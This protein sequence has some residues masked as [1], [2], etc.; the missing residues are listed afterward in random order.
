MPE[1]TQGTATT[2]CPKCKSKDFKVYETVEEILIY[3]VEGGLV[4]RDTVD[5][6]PGSILGISC[7]CMKCE[8]SWKPRGATSI[9]HIIKPIDE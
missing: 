6:E 3:Y 1:E 2:K 5:H 9:D 8:H 7:M 4:P